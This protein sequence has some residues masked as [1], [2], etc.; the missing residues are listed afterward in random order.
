MN[1][2]TEQSYSKYVPWLIIA[3]LSIIWGSSFILI[4]KGL[5]AFSPSQVGSLRMFFAFLVLSP[6]ALRSLNKVS[7]KHKFYIFTVGM[8]GNFIPAF[9]FAKAETN[10]SSSVTGILNALTPV[11]TM[12]IAIFVFK[13]KLKTWQVIGLLIALVGSVGISFITSN[14]SFGEINLYAFYVIIATLLYGAS[15]NITKTYLS[16]VK[17]I[18]ISSLAL[19]FVGPLGLA[20]VLTTD[21]FSVIVHHPQGISSLIYIFILGCLGTAFALIFYNKLIHMTSA[22]F[23]STVTYVMPIVAVL[24]GIID[25]EAFSLLHL[26]GMILIIIGVYKVNKP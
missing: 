10:L 25:G 19:L 7:N 26:A 2:V 24:W 5:E 1:S 4:K 12:L 22:V 6:I 21:V 13:L 11:F 8:I 18:F 17:P 20:Y 3:V 16:G 14:G 9:L 15:S 23:A